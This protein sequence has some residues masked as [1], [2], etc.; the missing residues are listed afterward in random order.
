MLSLPE[1]Y[2]KQRYAS[3]IAIRME[4]NGSISEFIAGKLIPM[5][6]GIVSLIFYLI[7][8]LVYSPWLGLLV[9][10]TTGFN[11]AVIQANLRAQ[12]DDS[13]KLQKD[14][15]KSDGVIVAA[16]SNMET[17]KAG[18][19]E[20]DIY[21]RFSG[22]HSRLLNT[23]Q[24][25]QLRNMRIKVFPSALTTV[26]EI[27]IFVLG[28]FLVLQGQLTLGMLL[29]AQTIAGSLK[30]SIEEIIGFVQELPEFQAE[31]LRLEDVL[32]Q[33]SDPLVENQFTNTSPSESLRRLSGEVTLENVD[34]GFVAALSS[35][36]VLGFQLSRACIPELKPPLP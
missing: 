8:T 28:F 36:T 26:N 4:S 14:D 30:S 29:A 16:M 35:S 31:L 20:D 15:A 24:G 21:R 10:I 18:A 2:Y 25:I 23:Q 19:L 12:K 13:L 22:Y 1:S 33:P 27:A 6:S 3:D 11:A 17:I 5:A 9:F 34:F 32:E 7:L